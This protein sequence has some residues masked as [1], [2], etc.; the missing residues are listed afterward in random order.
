MKDFINDFQIHDF[1][2]ITHNDDSSDESDIEIDLE[3]TEKYHDKEEVK[4]L[5]PVVDDEVTLKLLRQDAACIV[6]DND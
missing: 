2:G 4:A 6:I 1:T 5:A 3:L